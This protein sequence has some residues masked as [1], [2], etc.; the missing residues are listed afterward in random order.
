MVIPS[1][2]C[3]WLLAKYWQLASTSK[4][5]A[6]QRLSRRDPNRSP[7]RRVGSRGDNALDKLLTWNQHAGPVTHAPK[8]DFGYRFVGKIIYFVSADSA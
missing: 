8:K 1:R 5:A 2:H 7:S 6:A 4:H 3:A